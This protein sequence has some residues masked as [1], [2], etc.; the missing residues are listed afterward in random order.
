MGDDQIVISSGQVITPETVVNRSFTSAFRGYHPAEVKQFL[1][2]VSDEMTAAADREVEL[3]R[4]LQEALARAAHPELDE[5][6]VTAI[7]GEHAAK[8]LASARDTAATIVDEARRQA[9]VTLRDAEMRTAHMRGEAEGL[10]ARRVAEADASAASILQAAEAEAGARI[11]RATEQGKEMVGEARAVRERM[12]NDLSKRRRAAQ[13]Q[14]EQLRAVRERLMAAYE[15]VRRTVEEA[16]VELDAAEPEA[17]AAA[18][19]VARRAESELPEPPAPAPPRV[20]VPPERAR[21]P[22]PSG[23]AFRRVETQAPPRAE[24]PRLRPQT[25]AAAVAVRVPLP[26]VR[27]EPAPA[28]DRDPDPE[29]VPEVA[30]A[31]APA[32][33]IEPLVL[34]APSVSELATGEVPVVTADAAPGD[35]ESLFARLRADS[36]D[37][38]PLEAEAESEAGPSSAVPS[39]PPPVDP[40]VGETALEGR[41]DLLDNLEAGLTRALKRVLGDEQNEVLDGLRRL[42]SAA[43]TMVLP[44]PDVQAAGYRDAALPWLQ[45]AARAGIGFV[46]DPGTASDAGDAYADLESHAAALAR[47]LV[48]PLR[49][50]LSRALAGAAD[51]DDPSVVAE[52]LR[53]TYRQWKVAQVEEC[54][55]HHVVA[56]FSAGAFAATPDVATLQWLVDDDGHCPDCDDNALAGPT[57]KGEPFPTGQLHPPAHP[58]CRCL[59]VPITG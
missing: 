56:A 4:A 39:E 42:G 59:L 32:P 27:E 47:D 40:V 41:D 2:R 25:V 46:T 23:A 57:A 6:T 1:K 16:T 50:R 15:V 35:V 36:V 48:E 44:E 58:G 51:A 11:E 24:P 14:V 52:S 12:L 31:A 49:E 9:E 54:A 3:R 43:G 20:V 28:P 26:E 18:E 7:L 37:P 21:A 22:V 19:A 34:P 55:R 33:L 13:V 53:A 45:Q 10:M 38:G 17:L 29:P 5:A 8:L 30:I